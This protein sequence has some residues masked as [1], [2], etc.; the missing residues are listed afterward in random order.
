MGRHNRQLIMVVVV[1]VIG[2]VDGTHLPVLTFSEVLMFSF[3]ESGRDS[4]GCRCRACSHESECVPV[5]S[6]CAGI[7]FLLCAHSPLLLIRG[8]LHGHIP[9][10]AKQHTQQH[11]DNPPTTSRHKPAPV[12]RQ[13]SAPARLSTPYKAPLNNHTNSNI[14]II[15]KVSHE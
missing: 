14:I 4:R 3:L 13:T 7:C 8:F 1:I 6:G 15:N 12:K 5:R 11:G 10:C 2:A 9:C